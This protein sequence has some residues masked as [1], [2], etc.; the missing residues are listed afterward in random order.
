MFVDEK[1]K[2]MAK[3]EIA[4]TC[5]YYEVG[6][7][8]KESSEAKEERVREKKNLIKEKYLRTQASTHMKV[9]M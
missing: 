1:D 6:G 8:G 9:T 7:E 5:V 2:R 3:Y 4:C